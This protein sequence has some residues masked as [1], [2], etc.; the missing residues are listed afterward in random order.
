MGIKRIRKVDAPRFYTRDLHVISALATFCNCTL[1]SIISHKNLVHL[2][3]R[4]RPPPATV[5]GPTHDQRH[6]QGRQAQETWK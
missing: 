3:H 2:R 6:L 5:P 4:L 1:R